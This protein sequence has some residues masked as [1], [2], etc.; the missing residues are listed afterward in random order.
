[1]AQR[2][3]IRGPAEV[4]GRGNNGHT[5]AIGTTIAAAG[6]RP[7]IAPASEPAWRLGVATRIAG[8]P[9]RAQDS[10]RWQQ[11]PHLS[12]SLAYVRD[13]LIYL[14]QTQIR[15]YRLSS[16]LA[17]YATHPTLTAFHRQIDECRTELAALGDEVRAARIRLTMHPSSWVRLESAD[18]TLAARGR[19]ELTLAARLL[20]AMG[21][22]DNSVL[23]IHARQEGPAPG[24]AL[25]RVARQVELLPPEVRT[26]L[27]VENGDRS[28]DLGACLWLQRRTGVPVVFDVLHHRC[29]NPARLPL[30]EG[31]RLALATWPAAVRPK[32]HLSSPRTELRLIRRGGRTFVVPPLPNQH[33]DFINPFECIDLLRAARAQ[34]LRP[35]DLML[36]AKAHDLAL[37]RLRSQIAAYAPDLG[38]LVG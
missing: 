12:V 38:E 30:A 4:A 16:H 5:P 14:Q 1:M 37:L 22:D 7:L 24:Q 3:E 35:F 17:P 18:E 15:L 11:D 28:G 9:L 34:G 20:D 25:E 33:S 19:R 2:G 36:E 6:T 8:A 27:A 29:L 32:I 26:R 23:V 31:L 10:R 13:I 21:L